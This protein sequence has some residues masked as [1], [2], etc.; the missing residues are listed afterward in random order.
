[1]AMWARLRSV[2]QKENVDSRITEERQKAP[3][4]PSNFKISRKKLSWGR[5]NESWAEELGLRASGEP[6]SPPEIPY[7]KQVKTEMDRLTTQLQLMTTDRNEL[8]DRLTLITEGSLDN[9]PYHRPNPFS[10]K[11]KTQHWTLQT[12][13]YE[14]TEASQNFKELVKETG[15]YSNLHS[16]ILMEQT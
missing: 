13:E 11:L 14:H 2:F 16:Q 5:H 8:Q 12:L 6:P 7:K 1:M 10:E 4:L 9:R 3:G 15:F